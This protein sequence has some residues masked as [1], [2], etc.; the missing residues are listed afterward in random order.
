MAS[1]RVADRILVLG[2]GRLLEDGAHEQLMGSG[3]EY[4]RMFA[5]QARWYRDDAPQWEADE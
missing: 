4:A 5:L 2:G 1:A 3:G